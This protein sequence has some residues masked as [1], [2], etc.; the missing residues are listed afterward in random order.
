MVQPTIINPNSPPPAK[1]LKKVTTPYA[2]VPN[3]K[4]E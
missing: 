1:N 3:N 2:R 4:E